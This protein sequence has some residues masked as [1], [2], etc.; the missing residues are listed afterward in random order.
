MGNT[1]TEEKRKKREKAFI[2]KAMEVQHG[3]YSYDHFVFVN[4][5]TKG[6]ITCPIHGDFLQTPHNHLQGQ[7]CPICGKEYAQQWSKNDYAHFLK[8]A[9]EKF[10]KRFIYSNIEKEYENNH[11]K[12]TIKCNTC[13]HIFTKRAGDHL[14][15]P[16][17]G[18]SGHKNHEL[19]SLDFNGIWNYRIYDCG[20]LCYEWKK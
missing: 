5:H 10:G 15:S 8:R 11:S 3:K 4:T 20:C 1:L 19:I 17:G 12:I 14:S 2:E 18:C 9:E 13:G 7:G 16:N 6:W